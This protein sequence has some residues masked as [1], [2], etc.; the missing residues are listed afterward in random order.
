ME[1]DETKMINAAKIPIQK[2]A[3]MTT[4]HEQKNN[5]LVSSVTGSPNT[6]KKIVKSQVF[7]SGPEETSV[8]DASRRAPEI[9][10]VTESTTSMVFNNSLASKDASR[11]RKSTQYLNS[12]RHSTIPFN[13][14][15]GRHRSNS[16]MAARPSS[17]MFRNQHMARPDS[18]TTGYSQVS[19]SSTI[20]QAVFGNHDTEEENHE[21]GGNVSFSVTLFRVFLIALKMMYINVAQRSLE[22]FNCTYNEVTNEYIFQ[23]QT[24]R[25][26]F[27]NWWYQLLPWSI[28]GILIYVIGIPALY[29]FLFLKRRKYLKMKAEHRNQ[30]QQ[31]IVRVT[32]KKN[33]EFHE[34]ARYWD[35]VLMVQSLGLVS[36]QMFFTQYIVSRH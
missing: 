26:C 23:P 14:P 2:T 30:S 22:L 15:D 25:K 31:F 24:S 20:Y 1:P 27:E 34:S 9:S 13:S 10:T 21:G 11:K 36:C 16:L 5:D 18:E 32:Y 29:V 17:R 19:A 33:C 28:A 12:R 35:A 4:I 6:Q 7:E 3:T 8:M